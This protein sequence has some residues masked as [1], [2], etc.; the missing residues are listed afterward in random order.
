MNFIETKPKGAFRIEAKR[1]KDEG[2]MSAS[3]FN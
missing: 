1:I 3:Q 2:E